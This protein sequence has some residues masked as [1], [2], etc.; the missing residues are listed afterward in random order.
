MIHSFYYQK[1]P[2]LQVDERFYLRE[3]SPKDL[4]DFFEYYSDPETN[5]YILAS[6]PQNLAEAKSE[7]QY[8]RKMFYKK[9]GIY[10]SLIDKEKNK[11]IG[12]IGLYLNNQHHRAEIC[13]DLHKDY[14]RKGVMSRA[15]LKVIEFTFDKIPAYRVEAITSKNNI[16]SIRI[17]EKLGFVFE[18]SLRNYRYFKGKSADVELFALTPDMFAK[19]KPLE[20]DEKAEAIAPA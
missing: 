11:M 1:F 6:I 16:P 5:Q 8:C 9:M 12:A 14:W 10:W 20:A 19:T 15:M 7:I 3:Q 2:K 17:L 18:G 13:Y 4:E